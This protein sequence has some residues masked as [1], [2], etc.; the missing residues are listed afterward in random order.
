[1]H[2]WVE[3]LP[4]LLAAQADEGPGAF[5]PIVT[6]G[7]MFAIVYFMMIRPQGKQQKEH[8]DFLSTLQKGTEVVTSGG[9]VGKIHSVGAD[10]VVVEIAKDVRVQVVKNHVYAWKPAAAG[11][12]AAVKDG[13]DSKEPAEQKK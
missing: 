10:S 8:A 5:G 1:M 4:N 9:L 12:G 7:L 3:L 13:K 11:N 2:A 6:I